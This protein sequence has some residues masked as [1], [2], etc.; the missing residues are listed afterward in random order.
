MLVITWMLVVC[1]HLYFSECMHM[2][3]SERPQPVTVLDGLS[4]S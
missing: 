4:L 2:C 1:V 3:V